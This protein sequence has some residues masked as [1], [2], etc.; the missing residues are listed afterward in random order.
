MATE[1]SLAV[2]EMGGDRYACC[3][4]L[5]G[6]EVYVVE[7]G[8]SMKCCKEKGTWSMIELRRAE[9]IKWILNWFS[10]EEEFCGGIG[11]VLG[12]ECLRMRLWGGKVLDHR[13]GRSGGV[14]W[15]MRNRNSMI[16]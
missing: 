13:P 11:W 5:H 14:L 8:C 16:R 12:Y 9:W 7:A 15:G 2:S 1:V 3:W 6:W 10:K 4:L